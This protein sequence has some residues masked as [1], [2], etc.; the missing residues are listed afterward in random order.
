[1]IAMISVQYIITTHADIQKDGFMIRQPASKVVIIDIRPG[2]V[3]L[4]QQDG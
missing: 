3:D 4:F 1:M 2:F